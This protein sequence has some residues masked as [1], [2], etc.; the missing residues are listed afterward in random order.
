MTVIF[1]SVSAMSLDVVGNRMAAHEHGT[2]NG[3]EFHDY[4]LFYY[5]A[6]SLHDFIERDIH[7]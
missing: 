5:P 3:V 7:F 4:R 2:R 1:Q 6:V